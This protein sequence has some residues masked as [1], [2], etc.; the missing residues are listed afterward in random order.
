M[1]DSSICMLP[2]I[3]KPLSPREVLMNRS[4]RL[5]VADAAG[6]AAAL[7]LG[8][9]GGGSDYSAPPPAPTPAPVPAPPPPAGALSCGATNISAN[10]GHALALLPGDVDS[11]V[12][13]VYSIAGAADHNHLV[14]LSAAQL[15]QLKNKTAVTVVSTVGGDGHTHS[16]TVNCT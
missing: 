2:V 3:V 10:H 7:L 4:R 1:P 12:D 15:A 13:K 11:T 9:C 14:T 16:V 6:T 8:G 5:F